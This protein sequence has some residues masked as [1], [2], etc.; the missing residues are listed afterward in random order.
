MFVCM[1]MYMYICIYMYMYLT[2]SST[3]VLSE[4]ITLIDNHQEYLRNKKST[5][6]SFEHF[7]ETVSKESS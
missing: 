4:T 5:L 3:L 7:E 2:N 6:E 1:C